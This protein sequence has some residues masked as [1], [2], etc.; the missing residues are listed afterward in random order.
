M[1]LETRLTN[2]ENLVNGLIKNMNNNK[3]YSDADVNGCRHAEGELNEKTDKIKSDG[4]T[5][6]ET[7]DFILTDIIPTIMGE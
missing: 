5:T 7:I 6:T 4:I 1:D 2:L 3:F